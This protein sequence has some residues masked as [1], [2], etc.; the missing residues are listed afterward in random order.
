[1]TA[2][3]DD[4]PF[5]VVKPDKA[6]RGASAREVNEFHNQ[7]DTDSSVVAAHHTLGVK[8]TQASYGDHVHDGISSRKVGANMGLAISGVKNTVA[9]EDSIV[10]MLAKVIEFS[11]G[12]T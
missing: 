7:A 2:I 12:R 9:S 4:D 6:K 11:D 1:M 3:F 5:G 8:H 10:A